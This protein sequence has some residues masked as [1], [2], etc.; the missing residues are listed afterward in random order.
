MWVSVTSGI[1]ITAGAWRDPAGR[2]TA[3]ATVSSPLSDYFAI[4]SDGSITISGGTCDGD[5]PGGGQR[6]LCLWDCF[7]CR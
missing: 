6:H 7:D 2:H 5:S 4:G 3:V 1:G